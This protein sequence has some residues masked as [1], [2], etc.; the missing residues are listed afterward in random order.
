MVDAG[1]AVRVS[2]VLIQV[3]GKYRYASEVPIPIWGRYEFEIG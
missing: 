2:G 3:D 1:G